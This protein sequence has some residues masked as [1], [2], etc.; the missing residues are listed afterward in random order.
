M[1]DKPNKKIGILGGAG[2]AATAKF[3]SDL[4]DIAQKKYGAEQDTD[5]PYVYLY[6]MPMEGTDETGFL[7][8]DLVKKQ[9]IAGVKNIEACGADFIVI[10]CNTVH[11]FINEM[12]NAINIPIL[13]IIDATIE[14]IKKKEYKKIGVLS[15][16]STRT[17]ELYKKPIEKNNISVLVAST[18]EQILLDNII[19]AVMTGI[20]GIKE[21]EIM[22]SIIKR[23]ENQGAEAIILGC[24]ELPIAITQS[25]SNIPLISTIS[26][27]V[28]ETLKYTYEK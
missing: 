23:M 17:L 16:A 20:Q 28:N 21:K 3:F 11:F 26:V 12:R 19:L 2:P 14:E 27:L 4:I 25:D 18:E 24:T 8:P 1:N 15:S 6:N 10:P 5:F 22:K 7:D 9:L 13:S